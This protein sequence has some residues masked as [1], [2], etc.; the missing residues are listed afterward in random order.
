MSIADAV[1]RA[2]VLL[3]LLPD[4]HQRQ[5]YLD[6]IAPNLREGQVLDFASGYAVHFGLIEPPPFVD[7]V[8][9]VPAC[10]GEIA[11]RRYV[12]GKGTYGSFGVH[13]DASGNAR[14]VVMALA[15]GMGWL[16]FGCV[17]CSFGDEVAVNLFAETAGLSLVGPL[18]L[19]A[20]EVLIEA[21]FS[22]E[23]AFSETFY[24][25]QF[26]AEALTQGHVG[27]TSG[28]PTSVYLGLTQIP[29]ILDEDM[30]DKMRTMLRRVQ[31]G[32][33]VRDWNLEQLAGRPHLTQLKRE[34]P[35][36][37]SGTWRSCSWSA[38][39]RPAGDRHPQSRMGGAALQRGGQAPVPGDLRRRRRLRLH[40]EAHW[41]A[42]A[43][44][45]DRAAVYAMMMGHVGLEVP[46]DYVHAYV[47]RHP[48]K[49]VGVASVD[50][51][52]PA[53]CEQ[54]RHAVR[55]QGFRALK[56]SGA[57]QNF[58][59]SDVA[60][61][62]LYRTA[63]RLDIPIFWHQ[64]HQLLRG[65]PLALVQARAPRSGCATLSEAA[66]GD[67][68]HRP[69]VVHDAVMVARKHRNVYCDMSGFGF[70]RWRFYVSLATALEYDIGDKVLFGSDYPICS[71]EDSVTYLRDAVELARRT[72]LPEIPASFVDAVLERDS[73]ALLGMA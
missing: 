47:S 55:N 5:I 37:T 54:L 46:N 42:V 59:P 62:E 73:L 11:R 26:L 71:V 35:S 49:L 24:E 38:R 23:K 20:Y 52:D 27:D 34:R 32:E 30:R 33:L 9:C 19:M 31:S 72:G 18:M 51:H 40:A 1:R 14:N 58:D 39:R 17:E 15:L 13:Q 66:H 70:R 8:L 6:D 28:S 4:E 63:L 48:D 53:C 21:G 10:L 16:R 7:V 56:L 60:Y 67:L 22:A 45:V 29:K 61:D 2:D 12:E 57:Y 41:A 44:R 50:P 25:L 3:V 65:D 69:P 36:T 64:R 68:P 43:S